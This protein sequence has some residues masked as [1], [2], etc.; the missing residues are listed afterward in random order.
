[1]H[2]S[3][4]AK[5]MITGHDDRFK[6]GAED[7][8]AYLATP[9]GRLRSD[10]AFANLLD[11][12][13]ASDSTR[14]LCALDAGCGTGAMAVRLAE[15]G[16][17]VSALDSSQPMLDMA[18]CAAAG[19][20]FADR[21]TLRHGDVSCLSDLFPPAS[22]DVVLCHDLLEYVADPATVLRGAARMLRGPQAVLSL[23]VR[24]RAG[25]VLKSAIQAGDFSAAEANLD[26]EWG[27][28]SLYGGRVRLF[29]PV[30]L[31]AL[32]KAESLTAVAE[33]GIRVIADYLPA[34]TSR[35]SEYRRILELER[36]LGSR[37]EFAQVARYSQY[38]ALRIPAAD[39]TGNGREEGQ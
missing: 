11:F 23:V 4:S 24:N 12:L 19:S 8:Q 13:P 33:R 36:K 15:L 18:E 32:L 31:H 5:K 6:T 38:I 9:E 37:P 29:T 28:E 21:V 30:G 7:Y 2:L 3:H 16:F 25:E 35:V 22:F 26:A 1:L 34:S 27:F 14:D 20:G 39:L 17:H 10:L